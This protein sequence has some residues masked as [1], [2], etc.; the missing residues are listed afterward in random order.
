M[1][2]DGTYVR[3]RVVTNRKM[4]MNPLMI[5]AAAALGI[6]VASPAFAE[7]EAST[8]AAQYKLAQET[9][10]T[11]VP[12]SVA[13]S[14]P[15]EITDFDFNRP[16]P[17]GYTPVERTRRGLIVGGAVTF[18]VAYS[19][20]SLVAAAGEDDARSSSPSLLQNG[21]DNKFAALWIPVAGPFIAMAHADRATGRFTL[22]GLGAAQ[23]AGAI[24]LYFGLTTKD[25]VLVRNDLVGGVAVTPMAGPGGSGLA[26]S[27]RF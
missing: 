3:G 9:R 20:S 19:V 17:S 15:A 4:T 22:A 26:L 24:M 7:D 2:I 23:L 6:L 16:V 11:D 14:R 21:G 13:M 8:G 18:G 27:G 25:H 5:F 1:D 10:S 12:R